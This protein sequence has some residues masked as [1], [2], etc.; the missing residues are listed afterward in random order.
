MTEESDIQ[1]YS[2]QNFNPPREIQSF[3]R[4][5]SNP[6]RFKVDFQSAS[7]TQTKFKLFLHADRPVHMLIVFTLQ[8]LLGLT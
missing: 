4:V 1:L 2:N 5:S 7:R 8:T 6:T 3:F